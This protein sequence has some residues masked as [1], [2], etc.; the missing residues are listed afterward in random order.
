MIK[1]FI[2]RNNGDETLKIVRYFNLSER[3]VGVKKNVCIVIY[4]VRT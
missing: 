2:F 1:I 3:G 4:V